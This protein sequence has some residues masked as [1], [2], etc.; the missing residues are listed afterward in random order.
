MNGFNPKEILIKSIWG[1]MFGI[2][3]LN[4]HSNNIFLYKSILS[5]GN[6][7]QASSL[8]KNVSDFN[9]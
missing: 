9:L 4:D 7:S 5:S 1:K 2:Y 8:D 6:I 3:C